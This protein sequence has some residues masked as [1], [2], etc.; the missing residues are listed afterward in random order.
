MQSALSWDS[1]KI[2]NHKI[3][4]ISSIMT[5]PVIISHSPLICVLFFLLLKYVQILLS[6]VQILI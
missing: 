5:K 3:L 1:Q 6:G 2:Y 4:F